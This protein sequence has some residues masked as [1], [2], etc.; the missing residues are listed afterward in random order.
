MFTQMIEASYLLGFMFGFMYDFLIISCVM[1]IF[2]VVVEDAYV[3]AKYSKSRSWLVETVGEEQTELP[4]IVM[5]QQEAHKTLF[6][7]P[8]Q[9]E[10]V[11][12]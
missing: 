7:I 10:E 6:A 8:D 4:P 5:P 3:T 1:S 9:E 12:K 2:M 11:P